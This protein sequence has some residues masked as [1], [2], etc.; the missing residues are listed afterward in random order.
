[1]QINIDN[2]MGLFERRGF[3]KFMAIHMPELLKLHGNAVASGASVSAMRNVCLEIYNKLRVSPNWPKFVAMM[4]SKFRDSASELSNT[5]KMMMPATEDKNGVFS[6]YDPQSLR[7]PMQ[8]MFRGDTKLLP[9]VIS[10]FTSNTIAAESVIIGGFGYVEYMPTNFEGFV[11]N[12]PD[13]NW[14]I[15]IWKAKNKHEVKK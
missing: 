15:R 7:F 13:N 9:S 3:I 6:C 10:E 14:E 4:E 5:A 8:M 12:I 1:M 11:D 2:F